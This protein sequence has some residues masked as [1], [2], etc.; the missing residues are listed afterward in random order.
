MVHF[1]LILTVILASGVLL[2][3]LSA[4]FD[5]T[6]ETGLVGVYNDGMHGDRTALGS[7]Y[8][9]NQMTCAHKFYPTG[10]LLQISRVDN[11]L[12]VVVEVNDRLSVRSDNVVRLSKVAA[13]GLNY[14]PAR[15]TIVRIDPLGKPRNTPTVYYN[16][17]PSALRAAGDL[18]AKGVA[19]PQS[20]DAAYQQ[21]VTLADRTPKLQFPSPFG[22]SPT[23]PGPGPGQPQA[24]DK[25]YSRPA[26]PST[27]GTT[28]IR[29]IPQ[30]YGDL[31]A[32]GIATNDPPPVSY[33]AT[34]STKLRNLTTYYVQ[35]AAFGNYSNAE[36]YQ[37]NLMRRGIS[38]IYPMQ[39]RKEDGSIIYR[40]RIGPYPN[41]AEANKQKQ[42]LAR[43]YRLKGLVVEGN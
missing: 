8:D 6:A 30:S 40:M 21:P 13:Q 27:S 4:Q 35:V 31:T 39:A 37:Q 5:N 16:T 7:V 3:N 19:E 24:Y 25:A 36:R 11:G 20:Y 1:K 41:I 14:D 43:E 29:A 26:A 34:A 17:S 10:T 15:V 42:L 33:E 23:P 32:K 38:D 9:K 2:T 22:G 18:T 28:T 12:S